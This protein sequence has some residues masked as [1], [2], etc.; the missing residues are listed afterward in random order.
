[1]RPPDWPLAAI[2][3]TPE[4]NQGNLCMT[5]DGG[6]TWALVSEGLGPGYRSCVM[7][8]PVDKDQVVAAGFL[9]MDVSFDGGKLDARFGQRPLRRSICPVGTYLVVGRERARR[10]STLATNCQPS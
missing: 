1:M 7:H 10:M 2:G 5:Q 9:G 8:H 3:R 6:D 4:N